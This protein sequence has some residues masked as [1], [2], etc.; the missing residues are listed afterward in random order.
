MKK[1]LIIREG[2]LG[3]LILT[4]P[5]FYNFRKNGYRVS[6][7][8]KGI[9]K[10]IVE[11]IGYADDFIPIDSYEYL[12][13]FENDNDK[14]RKFFQR[15]DLAIAYI[16]EEEIL[17][18]NL[19]KFFKGRVF[20]HPVKKEKLNIHITDYL[21][22]PLKKIFNQN[23]INS[24]SFNLKTKGEF[25]VIHPGS[26]SKNKN[27]P[28]EKFLKLIENLKNIKLIL[29]P[30]EE[31]E[32]EFWRKNFK[33][34]IFFNIDIDNILKIAEKTI[35]YIGNDSGFTHLFSFLGVKTVAIFGPTSPFI[36]GP[37][38]ENV[39]IVYKKIEC[40]PCES[41]KMRNCKYKY[42]LEQI[43]VEDIIAFL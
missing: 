31:D 10:D 30:A 25:F 41:E 9:Y 8:G 37:R 1:V 40:N 15:F 36:W 29:G 33:D 32:I 28:K 4:F 12:F 18:I 2:A 35:A 16:D 42:C 13:L 6:V 22:E 24:V 17:G 11:K 38:G 39:K 34:E 3:D 7:A 43:K 21:L 26:G 27:W 20:F 5:V 23:F 14:L 19:K